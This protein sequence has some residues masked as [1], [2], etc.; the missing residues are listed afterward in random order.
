MPPT[1][2]KQMSVNELKARLE[3][4]DPIA[5]VDIRDAD[6]YADWHIPGAVNVPVIRAMRANDPEPLRARAGELPKDRAVVLV[7]NAGISSAKAAAVLD[8]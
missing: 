4:S 6:M 3:S 5:L 8:P 7:C 2:V 1:T